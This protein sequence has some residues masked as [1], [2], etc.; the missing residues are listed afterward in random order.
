MPLGGAVIAGVGALGSAVIGSEKAAGEQRAA[1]EAR[2]AAV[3]QWLSINV[4]DPA[5]Q[6]VEYEKYQIAGTLS[7]QLEKAFQQGQSELKNIQLDP[8]SRDAEIAALQQMQDLASHGGVD[9]QSKQKEAQ[10]LNTANTNE[11]GQ[12]G[13][14]I[15]NYAARGQGGSG[16][17]LAA[18]LEAQQGDS[19]QAASVG[20]QSAADA[21]QRALQAMMNSSQIGAN[22]NTQ[23]YNQ[24]AE[25]AKAQD[26]INRF[27]TQTQ[28]GVEGTN[29]SAKNAAQAANLANSQA[30]SNANTGV[31]NKQEQENKALVQ[32]QF[33]NQKSV[34]SGIANADA[35]VANQ[36][37][38]G[39]K[40]TANQWA[41]IGD[42]ISTGATAIG[43]Y[44]NNKSKKDDEDDNE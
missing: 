32:Q 42:A 28:Q 8:T 29:V 22:I 33:D 23:D 20:Q 31:A 10:A 37:N 17:E 18:L 30:V 25:S 2:D 3:K 14:I 26:A 44:E 5:Q 11:R 15:Q 16:A 40:N 39:A 7:P 41:G 9:A 43:Q 34:A 35:G 36:A 13:A 21:E 27:N 12:R 19:N 38:E 1:K 6:R 24:A 4:P